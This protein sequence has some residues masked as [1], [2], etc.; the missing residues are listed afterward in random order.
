MKLV[1]SPAKSLNWETHYPLSLK[2]TQPHFLKEAE[3]VNRAL[4]KYSPKKLSNLQSISINLAELNYLRNQNWESETDHVQG[5]PAIFAFDGDVYKGLNITEWVEEHQEKT[6][7]N[8]RILSGL[9]GVLRPFDVIRPYRLEMG[10]RLKIGRADNL[11]QFW[12][13]HIAASLNAEMEEGERLLNLASSEYFKSIDSR[14]LNRPTTQIEFK[15]RSKSGFKVM[16]F[17]AKKARGMM[18][19]HILENNIADLN[20]VTTFTSDGYFFDEENSSEEK[21]VFLNEREKK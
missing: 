19:R 17:Y 16:S 1:L 13:K 11:Y 21:L 2:V 14:I 6:Q 20:G 15:E 18:A 9:Y 12:K 3:K 8:L 4:K 7:N 5:R 10:T